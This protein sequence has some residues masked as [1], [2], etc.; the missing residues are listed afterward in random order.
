[1][2]RDFNSFRHLVS[3]CQYMIPN[4]SESQHLGYLMLHG[5]LI[6]VG[7]DLNYVAIMRKIRN[8]FGAADVRTD[9][10]LQMKRSL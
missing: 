5:A 9:T 4:E 3:I 6:K 2:P 10:A 8:D 7:S 1:M